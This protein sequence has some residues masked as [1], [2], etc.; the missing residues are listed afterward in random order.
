MRLDLVNPKLKGTI[1]CVWDVTPNKRN[2]ALQQ[3]RLDAERSRREEAEAERRQQ[4]LLIDVTSHELRNPISA[5]LQCSMLISQDLQ[6][7]KTQVEDHVANRKPYLLTQETVSLIDESLDA[8]ESVYECGLSQSRIC[9]DILSLGKLQ[10][11][12]LQVFPIETD[13]AKEI[14]KLIGIFSVEVRKLGITLS[15]SLGPGVQACPKVRMDPVR[16]GQCC[17][18][19]M[20]NAIKFT[21]TSDVKKIW[22]EIDI[23]PFSP[24][25]GT[26]VRPTQEWKSEDAGDD[27]MV[28]VSVKDTGPGLTE[29]SLNKLFKREL[30]IPSGHCH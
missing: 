5:V 29:A 20:T 22:L 16:F 11:D 1:G 13:I 10:L 19:I 12:K 24:S 23:S 9:D 6:Q 21:A 25:D 2:E 3:E 15:H 18:N 30:S 7:L 8:A 17:T 4:E 28:Y 26:C 14:S 27:L